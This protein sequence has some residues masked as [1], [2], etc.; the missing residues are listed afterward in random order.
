MKEIEYDKNTD[1]F[2][3]LTRRLGLW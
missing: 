3:R 2:W 1:L